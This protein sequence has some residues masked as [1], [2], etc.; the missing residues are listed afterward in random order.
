[1]TDDGVLVSFRYAS[2]PDALVTGATR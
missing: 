1:V 2:D